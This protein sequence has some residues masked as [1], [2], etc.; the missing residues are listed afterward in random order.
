MRVRSVTGTEVAPLRSDRT[1][2]EPLESPGD[3]G[4]VALTVKVLLWPGASSAS[5]GETEPNGT[6]CSVATRQGTVPLVPPSEATSPKMTP[7]HRPGTGSTT[8]TLPKLPGPCG[9][10]CAASLPRGSTRIIRTRE[11]NPTWQNS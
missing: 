9:S 2:I 1:T 4:V 8:S 11:F 3:D 6:A 7:V 5:D 10:E